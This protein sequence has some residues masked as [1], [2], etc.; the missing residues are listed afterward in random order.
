MDAHLTVLLEIQDVT[1]KVRELRSE[2]ELGKLESEHF[3]MDPQAAADELEAKVSE[4]EDRLDDRIRRRYDRIA[5]RVDRVLVPVINGMCYGC[6]VSIATATAGEQDPN[7]QL[8]TC[9]NCGRF[10]YILT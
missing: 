3:G 10:L 5:T 2:T 7:A 4:L 8:Q 1:A 6:F 9:E